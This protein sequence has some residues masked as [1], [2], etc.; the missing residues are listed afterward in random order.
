MLNNTTT[1]FLSYSLLPTL[2]SIQYIHCVAYSLISLYFAYSRPNY[3]WKAI[4]DISVDNI[5]DE[6]H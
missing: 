5:V 2:Y 3:I 4:G 6:R 1:C